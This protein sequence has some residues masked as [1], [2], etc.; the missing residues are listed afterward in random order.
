ML[1]FDLLSTRKIILQCNWGAFLNT[2]WNFFFY[3]LNVTFWQVICLN[4]KV[5]KKNEGKRQF[6]FPFKELKFNRFFFR[7]DLQELFFWPVSKLEKN[8]P[9]TSKELSCLVT[10]P[11]SF[12]NLEGNTYTLALSLPEH[13]YICNTYI[14]TSLFKVPSLL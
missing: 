1:Y 5:K 9:Y 3:S 8:H 6:T 13:N 2:Y 10:P 11:F 7:P 12:K 4:L 14:I